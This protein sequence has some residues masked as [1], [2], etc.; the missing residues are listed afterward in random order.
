M[1]GQPVEV[2]EFTRRMVS[3]DVAHLKVKV[4]CTKPLPSSAEIERGTDEVVRLSI[5]YPWTPP[6]YPCCKELGHLESHCPHAQW[7]SAPHPGVPSQAPESSTTPMPVSSSQDTSSP[8][9]KSVKIAEAPFN[10]VLVATASTLGIAKVAEKSSLAIADGSS[11]K[12]V[13]LLIT[14]P[15]DLLL[16]QPEIDLASLT[17]EQI[18]QLAGSPAHFS[19]RTKPLKA[20]RKPSSSFVISAD[21]SLGL[22]HVSPDCNPFAYLAL[23]SD[24]E[25]PEDP[26]SLQSLAHNPKVL[27]PST[28]P[29]G[30]LLPG[31]SPT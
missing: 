11:I 12:L 18:T 26:S 4:D 3:L 25:F 27:L 14:T 23:N 19:S 24:I 7:K 28:S 31:E 10:I 9:V 1:L 13:F 22:R 16:P 5:D 15:P 6:F 20:L 2:D 29:V 21:L 17:S 30:S 8:V